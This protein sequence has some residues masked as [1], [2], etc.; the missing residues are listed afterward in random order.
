MGLSQGSVPTDQG[1][2]LQDQSRDGGSRVDQWSQA[3]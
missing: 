1:A 3:Q 2:A